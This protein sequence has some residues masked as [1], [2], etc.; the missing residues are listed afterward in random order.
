MSSSSGKGDSANQALLTPVPAPPPNV[1]AE[2]SESPSDHVD[3]IQ[4]APSSLRNGAFSGDK[5][6]KKAS[7]KVEKEVEAED[8]NNFLGSYDVPVS[9]W[10]VGLQLDVASLLTHASDSQ[11]DWSTYKT[12]EFTPL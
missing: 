5:N 8:E 4:S 3:R 7:H 2:Y 10:S 9:L 1:H 11:V 6:N 12:F